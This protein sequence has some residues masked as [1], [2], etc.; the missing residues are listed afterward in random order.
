VEPGRREPTAEG[1]GAQGP[2][3]PPPVARPEAL[4]PAEPPNVVEE[5]GTPPAEPE[6][7]RGVGRGGGWRLAGRQW[8]EASR[9][10]QVDQ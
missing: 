8:K 10:A 2:G 5:E 4:H 6:S 1:L 9:H 7:H 3:A